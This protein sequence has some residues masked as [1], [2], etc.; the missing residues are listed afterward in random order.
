MSLPDFQEVDI[1][2]AS[3]DITG[4]SHYPRVADTGTNNRSNLRLK[5]N[6]ELLI[7]NRNPRARRIGAKG[8]GVE[9]GVDA[10]SRGNC[11]SSTQ[12]SHLHA[13]AGLARRKRSASTKPFHL[14][15]TSSVRLSRIAIPSRP[16]HSSMVE[17]LDRP[18]LSKMF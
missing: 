13:L 17:S 10:G 12:H 9:L 18:P 1:E 16:G 15:I 11:D 8:Q 6:V 3:D 4:I 14:R 2:I 7:R 5:I